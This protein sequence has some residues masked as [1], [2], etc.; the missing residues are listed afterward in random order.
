[1]PLPTT[2]LT[3]HLRAD[4][5]N[6]LFTVYNS[7]G[8]HSG[9][10]TDGNAV[11]VWDDEAD[12]IADVACIFNATSEPFYRSSVPLMVRS[13]LDFDGVDNYFTTKNQTGLAN[14]AL[15]NFIA[16]NAF[17]VAVSI[18]PEVI[19]TTAAQIY[20]NA[21]VLSDAGSF[22]GLHTKDESGVKKIYGFNWDGTEDKIGATINTDHSWVIIFR[23]DT[24][25]L[26]LR[27]IDESL[28]IV[29]V[30]DV[31]SGNTTNLTNPGLIGRNWD[32]SAFY[33]GRIMEIAL[34][35]ISVVGSDFTD[36]TQYFIGQTFNAV[37]SSLPM[38]ATIGAKRF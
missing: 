6:N 24:G 3:L 18:Y 29:D 34:Y 10:P 22:W 2:G 36:L 1:M 15:S 38:I 37:V 5:T 16:N 35:N 4:R 7:G 19:N 11:Q 21:A 32:N 28:N 8:A 13:C 20:N 27:T 30:T 23:H 31:A 9:V 17:T 12:G 25:N 26:K 33:N 14:K